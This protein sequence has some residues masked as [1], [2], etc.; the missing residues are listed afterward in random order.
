MRVSPLRPLQLHVNQTTIVRKN[1]NRTMTTDKDKSY[2]RTFEKSLNNMN[3]TID[4]QSE[5]MIKSKSK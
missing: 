1:G 3:N 4:I 2:G 5:T